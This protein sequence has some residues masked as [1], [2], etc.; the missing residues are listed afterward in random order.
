M[1]KTS[2]HDVAGRGDAAVV[3]GVAA[4]YHTC[5]VSAAG[6]VTECRMWRPDPPDALHAVQIFD[7]VAV[8][9]GSRAAEIALPAVVG[10]RAAFVLPVFLAREDFLSGNKEAISRNHQKMVKYCDQWLDDKFHKRMN[11]HR[12]EKRTLV[13]AHPF[14]LSTC[15][16]LLRHVIQLFL[17]LGIN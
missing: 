10:I 4:F 11:S 17:F 6:V 13:I 9:A 16:K 1:K 3:I 12:I 7:T 2:L 15:S 8:R 5:G 14:L